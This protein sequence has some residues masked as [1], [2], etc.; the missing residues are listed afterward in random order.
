MSS[1]DRSKYIGGSDVAAVLGLSP[2]KTPYGLWAEKKGLIPNTVL[3]EGAVEWGYRLEAPIA[4]KFADTNN[5]RISNRHRV[6]YHSV[7]KYMRG[8]IDFHI[9]K[10]MGDPGILEVK[11]AGAFLSHQW[12]ADDGDE[13]P[14]QYWCQVQ[15]YMG[16]F[17]RDYCVI[18][19]LIG[20]QDYREYI[21]D[22][23]LEFY[24][25]MIKAVTA[26]WENNV[27]ANVAPSLVAADYNLVASETPDRKT[28]TVFPGS[29]IHE[30]AR[31]AAC[32]KRALKSAKEV[33]KLDMTL[34]L[35]AL[36]NAEQLIDGETGETILTRNTIQVNHTD[37][38]SAFH[39][40]APSLST[41]VVEA[42]KTKHHQIKQQT[43]NNLKTDKILAQPH[44][45]PTTG[46]PNGE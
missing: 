41:Q 2:Y 4:E 45:K 7:Y 19:A 9:V 12:S 30:L 23:D 32:S 34:L 31:R 20:G 22:F 43:R 15:Y 37:W 1:G 21:I 44:K 27:L 24:N 11:T 36:E 18:A 10:G 39:S 42:A 3:N 35:E 5:C 28:L 14:I 38:E 29:A 26:F 46:E 16:L 40:L 17:G 6:A 33:D 13:V 8:E 25:N